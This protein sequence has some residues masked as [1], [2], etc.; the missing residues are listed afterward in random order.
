[1]KRLALGFVLMF[2][3]A[4]GGGTSSAPPFSGASGLPTPRPA[5]A[6]T[7][8]PT[9]SPTPTATATATRTPTPEPTPRSFCDGVAAPAGR[10]AMC[11]DGSWSSSQNRSGTCSSHDGVRCWVCPGPLC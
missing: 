11:N 2:V 10:T 9:A 3:A 4:C 1:M 8:I 6:A 5:T 7:A